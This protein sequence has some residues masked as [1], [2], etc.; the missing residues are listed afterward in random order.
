[1]VIS[2]RTPEGTPN[3]CPVCQSEIQIDPSKP[4]L[5]APCPHCGQL[6]WFVAETLT[7]RR[8]QLIDTVLQITS[9]RFGPL[10]CEMRAEIASVVEVERLEQTLEF[11]VKCDNWNQLV[12]NLRG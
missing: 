10:S 3:H 6:L 2:S 5:D 8:Q 12:A 7:S 9:A 11:A 4:T 1:V